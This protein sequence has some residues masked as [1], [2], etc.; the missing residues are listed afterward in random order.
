MANSHW[1]WSTRLG[2]RGRSSYAH[3]HGT[4][5][6]VAVPAVAASG[7]GHSGNGH[8]KNHN[9]SAPVLGSVHARTRKEINLYIIKTHLDKAQS[10]NG[11]IVLT[12]NSKNHSPYQ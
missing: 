7:N 4:M 9:D 12:N 8:S 3:A 10:T 11:L 5:W 1:E 6:A 2:F